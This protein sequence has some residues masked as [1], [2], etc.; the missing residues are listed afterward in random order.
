M[1]QVL[2]SIAGLIIAAIGLLLLYFQIREIQNR[3]EI[4]HYAYT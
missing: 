1:L 2:L 3:F 4:P